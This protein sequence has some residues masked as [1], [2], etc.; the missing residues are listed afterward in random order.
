[1]TL[2]KCLLYCLELGVQYTSFYAFSLEN[3]KRSEKEVEFLMNLARQEFTKLSDIYAQDNIVDII[4]KN[5]VKVI[6]AGDLEGQ[7]KTAFPDVRDGFLK[8]QERTK[9]NT[10]MTMYLCFA[11][12]SIYEYNRAVKLTKQPSPAEQS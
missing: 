1:L 7:L 8:I 6:M 9:N 12:D 5:N 2:K 11:Y 4:E 3:Y 10:R